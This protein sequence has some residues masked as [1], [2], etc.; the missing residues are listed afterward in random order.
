MTTDKYVLPV[1][2]NPDDVILTQ[3]AFR[4]AEIANPLQVT[5][6]GVAA[7]DFLFCRGRY[8]GRDPN[9]KPAL[10]LLDIKLPLINGVQVFQAIHENTDTSNIPVIVLTSSMEASDQRICNHL[11]V[12]NY[13]Q[14]PASLSKFIEIVRDMKFE[15][16][17]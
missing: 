1:E 16:L 12:T 15:W 6:D 17:D 13:L 2:D 9:D 3:V 14:K 4:K 5:A 7:M 11:G 10:I 8:A